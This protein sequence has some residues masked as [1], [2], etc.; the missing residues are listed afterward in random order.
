MGGVREI[1]EDV[2]R[3]RGRDGVF[4]VGDCSDG[5]TQEI[6]LRSLCT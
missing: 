1:G 6:L 2:R 4:Y 5:F 3:G